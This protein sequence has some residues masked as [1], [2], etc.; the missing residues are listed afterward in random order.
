MVRRLHPLATNPTPNT[1]S[2][3]YRWFRGGGGG[4]SDPLT[5]N[6]VRADVISRGLCRP[7]R[8][9]SSLVMRKTRFVAD[10]GALRFLLFKQLNVRQNA[11]STYPSRKTQLQLVNKSPTGMCLSVGG[12]SSLRRSGLS[13]ASE[14]GG[15]GSDHEQKR[16]QANR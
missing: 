6:V 16:V 10:F 11:K 14:S 15:L 9:S 8:G 7:A 13:C 12:Y 5:V 2:T 3:M 1:L 4:E